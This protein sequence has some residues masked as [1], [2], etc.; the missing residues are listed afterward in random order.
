VSLA[1]MFTEGGLD[2]FS[3]LTQVGF[4]Y[5]DD[6]PSKFSMFSIYHWWSIAKAS[7]G[8]CAALSPTHLSIVQKGCDGKIKWK[9]LG[10]HMGEIGSSMNDSKR[11]ACFTIAKLTDESTIRCRYRWLQYVLL[12]GDNECKHL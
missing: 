4:T 6:E 7:A 3:H 9:P 8:L 12:Y 2:K 11:S 10:F 1:E 5:S